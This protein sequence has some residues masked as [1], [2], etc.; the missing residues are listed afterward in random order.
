MLTGVALAEAA[1][2]YGIKSFD[3]VICPLRI[4]AMEHHG[5]GLSVFLKGIGF[6]IPLMKEVYAS[7]YAHLV[8]PILSKEF[9]SLD[10][11]MKKIMLK[12]IKQCVATV[13]VEPE[14]I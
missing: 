2:P 7:H 3:S 4:G 1:Y 9:H 12:V 11:E 14:Y 5:K 6:I 8:M 13:G 10:K